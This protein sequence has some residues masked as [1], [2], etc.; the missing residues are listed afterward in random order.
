[1]LKKSTRLQLDKKRCQNVR[2]KAGGGSK[3]VNFL[4]INLQ[5]SNLSDSTVKR[6]LR[7]TKERP[8]PL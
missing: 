4:V 7:E 1:M 8:A 5:K 2:N 6:D 3:F